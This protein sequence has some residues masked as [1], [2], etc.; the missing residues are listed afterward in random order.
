[1]IDQIA[2]QRELSIRERHSRAGA[3]YARMREVDSDIAEFEPLGFRLGLNG[4]PAQQRRILRRGDFFTGAPQIRRDQDA[5]K[6]GSF[7]FAANMSSSMATCSAAS[8]FF[9]SARYHSFSAA[10]RQTA[11]IQAGR[12]SAGIGR[13][14]A[15]G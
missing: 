14:E 13:A 5:L 2:E 6:S 4:G 10:P 7:S 9:S 12:A 1:M 8:S 15:A 3:E 11:E